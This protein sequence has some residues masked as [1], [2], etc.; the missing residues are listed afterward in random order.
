MVLNAAGFGGCHARRRRSVRPRIP[1]DS[2]S[3]RCRS[4][5]RSWHPANRSG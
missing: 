2:P 5:C 4:R 3:S 1:R